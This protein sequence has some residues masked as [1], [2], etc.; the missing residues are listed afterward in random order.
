MLWLTWIMA[1]CVGCALLAN[2]LF[3]GEDK[4]LFMPGPLSDGH[5]QFSGSCNVC[6]TDAFAG[7]AVLQDSCIECHGDVRKKPFDSHPRAKFTDPRNADL[8][9]TI[10]ATQ[11]IT[12]H[13]EHKSE[14]T[15]TNGLTKPKDLCFHCHQSIAE[16]RPSHE[17][18]GFETCAT[19]GCHNFHDN[20]ALYTDFLVKRIDDPALLASPFVP[21]KEFSSVLD[22]LINY[23]RDDYPVQ[24]FTIEQ[25]DA[26]T[27]ININ[28][29]IVAQWA[30][31][32]HAQQGA[33]CSACHTTGSTTDVESSAVASIKTNEVATDTWSDTPGLDACTSCHELEVKTFT[34]GKHGM[35]YS[36]NL[37]PMTPAEARLP[38]H[39]SKLHEELSCNSCHGAHDYNVITAAVESC[40]GC[41][42]DQHTLAYKSSLHYELWLAEVEGSAE[43]GSGVSCATCHMPRVSMDVDDYNS[44]TVVDHN[45]S[46]SLAPNSKMLR[47]ACLECHGLAFSIDAL[48]DQQLIDS[49]FKGSSSVSVESMSMAKELRDTHE[50]RKQAN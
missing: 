5:H 15:Q 34:Q 26:P 29:S 36:A 16:E 42:S 7:G 8:L 17:G 4:S 9:S 35:R 27:H 31:S 3:K 44:R 12:C 19:S 20:R 23:P 18:M 41:H 14:I 47:P 25:A 28:E 30:Q 21:Q 38:M 2:V 45:Q 11:C 50:R 10:D 6:H 40:V 37:P 22:L 48:A 43:P 24:A 13:T 39:E 49:N 46:A 33:N 32:G 1:S